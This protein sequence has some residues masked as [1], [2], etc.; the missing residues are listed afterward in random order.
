VDFFLFLKYAVSV[1][2]TRA[3]DAVSWALAWRPFVKVWR[4]VRW[5]HVVGRLGSSQLE[6]L[7]VAYLFTFEGL[8][9][10]CALFLFRSFRSLSLR[11][12][13]LW[14]GKAVSVIGPV[15]QCFAAHRGNPYRCKRCSYRC[16][17]CIDNLLGRGSWSW[18]NKQVRLISYSPFWFPTWVFTVCLG[19]FVYQGLRRAS[20]INF[21]IVLVS[22]CLFVRLTHVC[23]VSFDDS[24][25]FW[26]LVGRFRQ[27]QER[28]FMCSCSGCLRSGIID[29]LV[30][31]F[32]CERS[33]VPIICIDIQ[34]VP[35]ESC[36]LI[37]GGS[38]Q[39]V[40]AKLNTLLGWALTGWGLNVCAFIVVFGVPFVM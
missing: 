36:Y 38:I 9:R 14:V 39:M 33:G 30:C 18:L 23:A 29:T 26:F 3:V 28:R 27:W 20:H 11:V 5:L 12:G 4:L 24:L 40:G 1:S 32:I 22:N 21:G 34:T 7:S 6:R 35:I 19:R 2:T 10:V 16:V 37:A 8:N 17:A 31:I 13:L 25:R 15:R